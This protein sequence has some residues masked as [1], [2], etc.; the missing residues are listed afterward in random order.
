MTS[1]KPAAT[2]KPDKIKTAALVRKAYRAGYAEGLNEGGKRLNCLATS[3]HYLWRE[4][5]SLDEFE[6]IEGVRLSTKFVKE[7][8]VALRRSKRNK[9]Y[10]DELSRRLVNSTRKLDKLLEILNQCKDYK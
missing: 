6:P 10:V 4:L 2:K 3:N 1:K 7:L 8:I 5:T 9:Y